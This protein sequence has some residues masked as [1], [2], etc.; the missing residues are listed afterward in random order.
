LH[1]NISVFLDNY[2]FTL[3]ESL[4][5]M[6]KYYQFYVHFSMFFV[7]IASNIKMAEGRRVPH[8]SVIL[9]A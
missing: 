5:S 6:V 8:R 7:G 2:E 1:K 4:Y 9:A 3:A